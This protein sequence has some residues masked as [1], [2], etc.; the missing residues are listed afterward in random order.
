MEPRDL[1]VERMSFRVNDQRRPSISSQ[2]PEG[3]AILF[4]DGN[5]F[6]LA[7]HVTP[8]LVKLLITVDGG[9]EVNRQSLI[10]DGQLR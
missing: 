1:H 3:P 6:R 10:D 4:A 9:E 2:H 8:A 7:P 5:P